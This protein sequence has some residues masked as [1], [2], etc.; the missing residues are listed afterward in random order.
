MSKIGKVFI[1]HRESQYV[2][3][4]AWLLMKIAIYS[5]MIKKKKK[6]VVVKISWAWLLIVID[7]HVWIYYY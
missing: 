3:I 1:S 7:T 4:R 2:N 5:N 6:L